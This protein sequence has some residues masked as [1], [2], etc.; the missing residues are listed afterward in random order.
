MG[1]VATL[2]QVETTTA[3]FVPLA[4]PGKDTDEDD[5]AGP[6]LRGPDPEVIYIQKRAIT[7][8]IRGTI[9][10]IHSVGGF[11]ARWRG[12][13]AALCTA[14][15]HSIIFQI[16]LNLLSLLLPTF[17]ASIIGGVA[18]TVILARWY[19][20]WTHIVIS[21]P[22]ST[23]WYR[24]IPTFRTWRNIWAPTAINALAAQIA[25][26]A[27]LAMFAA[28][29]LADPHKA[30]DTSPLSALWKLFLI[31]AVALL[32]YIAVVLPSEVALTRC[33]ASMLPEE[34][35]S[36]VPFDRSFGGKVTPAIVGGTGM[37]SFLDAWRSFDRPARLRLVKLY[38]KIF[39]IDVALHLLFGIVLTLELVALLGP[40]VKK[41]LIS[42]P[43]RGH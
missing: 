12:I 31:L 28:L 23:V 41:A 21:D 32:V 37:L 20:A 22:V 24:R 14:V 43:D 2:A 40:N 42:L 15:A 5:N 38:A 39:A 6:N 27:P 9:R 17:L 18:T 25:F 4:T 8:S 30:R 7:S 10:H 36:I 26:L 16:L 11:T 19:M 34:A 35:E 3:D 13:A 29:G 1:V 33:Q